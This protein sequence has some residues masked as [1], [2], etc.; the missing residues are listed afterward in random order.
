MM[1]AEQ[2]EGT[3]NFM[4]ATLALADLLCAAGRAD[5]ATDLLLRADTAVSVIT[6]RKPEA[7]MF[8]SRLLLKQLRKSLHLHVTSS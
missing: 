7:Y 2:V 3:A 6:F 8:D 5:A 4:E 1:T